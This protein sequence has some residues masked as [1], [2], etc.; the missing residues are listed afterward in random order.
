MKELFLL[1]SGVSA[2]LTSSLRCSAKDCESCS[3]QTGCL[4]QSVTMTCMEA[5]TCAPVGACVDRISFCSPRAQLAKALQEGRVETQIFSAFDHGWN[6]L[7]KSNRANLQPSFTCQLDECST[8]ME[9]KN[10][11]KVVAGVNMEVRQ[12]TDPKSESSMYTKYMYICICG[13][14]WESGPN[15]RYC[16]RRTPSGI[17]GLGP[18]PEPGPGYG[19]GYYNSYSDRYG[20]VTPY[21]L[22][23]GRPI[24]YERPNE[25]G[26]YDISPVPPPGPPLPPSLLGSSP[27]LPSS[28]PAPPSPPLPSPPLPYALAVPSF[29]SSK[30]LQN[31]KISPFKSIK[32]PRLI[33]FQYDRFLPHQ[34]PVNIT[35]NNVYILENSTARIAD[36]LPSSRERSSSFS[37]TTS[38]SSSP[39]S[40]R[41]SSFVPASPP[42]SFMLITDPPSPELAPSFDG[43]YRI[44]STT[45][46][47]FSISS[48]SP[49]S[50]PGIT[51][52]PLDYD[53][54]AT[55]S[56]SAPTPFNYRIIIPG[57]DSYASDG[58]YSLTE[59]G[60][61]VVPGEGMSPNPRP[62]PFE[63]YPRNRTTLASL[64]PFIEEE[65]LDNEDETGYISLGGIKVKKN[66]SS[67]PK[68]N[69]TKSKDKEGKEDK[70][71]KDSKEG[72][73]SPPE[74]KGPEG[75]GPPGK[76]K[77]PRNATIMHIDRPEDIIPRESPTSV[78]TELLA[79]PLSNLP[80][81]Y[82][83]QS[84]D[85]KRLEFLEILVYSL[86]G[87]LGLVLICAISKFCCQRRKSSL[88]SPK[89]RGSS[90]THRGLE[91]ASLPLSR[92]SVNDLDPEFSHNSEASLSCLP[93]L[94]SED[95]DVVGRK[96]CE[97]A[98]AKLGGLPG[99]G[100]SQVVIY[101][102]TPYASVIRPGDSTRS[103]TEEYRSDVLVDVTLSQEEPLSTAS[104]SSSYMR[105]KFRYVLR[106]DTHTSTSVSQSSRHYFSQ[107]SNLS[108]V[109]N[110]ACSSSASG[111]EY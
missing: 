28:S 108:L 47:T 6:S 71:D 24:E 79:Q 33:Q 91:L 29:R 104:N 81:Y 84:S 31:K 11:C 70:D 95:L 74:G 77:L 85:K 82:S 58:E 39:P 18:F 90:D 101:Y 80:P 5:T 26:P 46:P 60:Y 78:P 99:K 103:V 21:N 107:S 73:K 52:I 22:A 111:T 44:P 15:H 42:S 69:S 87:V 36:T 100:M 53:S 76:G 72:N 56:P 57:E 62:A 45:S 37:S 38:V 83:L 8:S 92:D 110:T 88:S 40:Y 17:S 13:A 106:R 32:Q 43:L 25:Y 10:F 4:W 7:D 67:K 93:D 102:G 98:W 66:T 89:A 50:S 27:A 65:L 68:K 35:A 63:E 109:S 94:S 2:I 48:S 61:S 16:R 1:L 34:K 23:S 86:S 41:D 51:L 96:A 55:P 20:Y 64:I 54:S 75:K 9:P 59:G 14:E 3:F 105:T 30:S 19:V 12:T 97:D 49:S